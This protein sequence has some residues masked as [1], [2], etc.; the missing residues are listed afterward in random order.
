MRVSTE[1]QA[2]FIKLILTNIIKMLTIQEN[3]GNI[4]ADNNTLTKDKWIFL[5]LL[6][7]KIILLWRRK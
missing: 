6:L 7:Y 2:S 5:C 1:D 3:Y 4:I